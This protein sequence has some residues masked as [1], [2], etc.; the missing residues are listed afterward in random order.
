MTGMETAEEIIHQERKRMFAPLNQALPLDPAQAETDGGARIRMVMVGRILVMH[1]SMNQ[2]NGEILMEMDTEMKPMAM[3]QMPA[4]PFVVHPFLTGSVVVTQ[5]AMVGLILLMTGMHIHMVQPML[6]QLKH[7]NGKTVMQMALA[8][9]HSVLF[10]MIVLKCL[11]LRCETCKDVRITTA[12]VG[13]MS[14][15]SGMLHS[16]SWEKTQQHHG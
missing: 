14:T 13:P 1:S 6:S 2:L 9:S 8:M 11:V 3:S 7:C 4:P 5:M 12:M 16:L 10:E 15:V